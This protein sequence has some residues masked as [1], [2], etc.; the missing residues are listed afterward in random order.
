VAVTQIHVDHSFE[1]LAHPRGG[2]WWLVG[3][4]LPTGDTPSA[5]LQGWSVKHDA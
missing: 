1:V 4:D 3:G 5:I 2:Q